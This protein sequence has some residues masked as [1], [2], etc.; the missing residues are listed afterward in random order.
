MWEIILTT[1]SQSKPCIPQAA[2]RVALVI[3]LKQP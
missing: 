1:V 2:T 3:S